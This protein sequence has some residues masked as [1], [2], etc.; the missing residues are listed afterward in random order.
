[1]VTMKKVLRYLD[2]KKTGDRF[3]SKCKTI[4]EYKTLHSGDEYL[5]YLKFSDALNVVYTTMM[6]GVGMPIL[7]PLAALAVF[8]QWVGERYMMAKEVRLPPA[9]S[10]SLI[11][12]ANYKLT[13]APLLLIM[14]GYWML[15]NRQI[16]DNNTTFINKTGDLMIS[17]HHFDNWSKPGRHT[18]L[19]I[20]I[21][22][23][24]FIYF[25]QV[26]FGE[27]LASLGYSMT[28]KDV[29]VDEDLPNFFKSLNIPQADQILMDSLTI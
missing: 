24:F 15:D 4:T 1:M 8:N 7:F 21:I 17:D 16:F 19:M 5:I 18:P 23:S 13:L 14:N 9:M 3:V 25:L 28:S 2:S 22:A 10:N 29:S 26:F 6:Y 20:V 12:N 27:L 11:I